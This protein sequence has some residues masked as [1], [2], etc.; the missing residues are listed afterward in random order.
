MENAIY[1]YVRTKRT[2]GVLAVGSA[3]DKRRRL[4]E[5]EPQQETARHIGI[6]TGNLFLQSLQITIITVRGFPVYC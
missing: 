4:S 1:C 3:G 2:A 6:G 5:C